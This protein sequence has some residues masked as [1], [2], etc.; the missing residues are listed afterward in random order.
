MQNIKKILLTGAAALGIIL[1]VFAVGTMKVKNQDGETGLGSQS[2]VAGT[3]GARDIGNSEVNFNNPP[4]LDS[5]N[6]KPQINEEG[7]VSVETVLTELSAGAPVKFNITFTTHQG[8]LN[9]DLLKQAVLFDD[10]GKAYAPQSWDGGSGGHHLSG[11]LVFSSLPARTKKIKLVIKD[12]YGVAEREFEW[13][14][15]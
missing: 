13:E 6:S 2:L 11:N 4:K 7:G 12:I 3:S 1:I 10:Q 5:E 14:L 9:L 15:E 8:D